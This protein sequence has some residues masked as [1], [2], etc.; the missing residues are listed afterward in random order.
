MLTIEKI[1]TNNK[2]HV[3]RFT[4]LPFRLY[5]GHPQWV[6]PLIMDLETQLNRQRHPFFEHSDV[7]FFLAVAD[8]RDV[9]R[10]AAMENK[11]F[12]KYHKTKKA[13]FY[14]FDCEDDQEI[15]DKLF[16]AVFEWARARGLDNVVGPKGM[17]P[18]DGYG[19]QTEGF[20]H[21]QMMNMM[22]Y[23]YPYYNK[24]VDAAGFTREV[25]FVSCYVDTTTFQLPERVHRIA[26]RVQKRGTLRVLKMETKKDLR[27][28]ASQV[29]VAYNKAF[30]N[31]W[32]YYPLSEREVQFVVDTLMQV[33]VP[34]LAKL[35]MHEDDVV[36]FVLGFPDISAAMQR[37]K[38]KLLPFGIIDILLEMRRTRWISFNG[39]GIL[40]EFQGRGGNALL[41]SEMVKTLNDYKF[42]HAELTQVANTA[43]EMRADLKNL[44]SK[45][46][47]NHRVYSRYI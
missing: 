5:A 39:A 36:G 8:G 30:V 18:F 33:L 19:I 31:N 37:I 11:P 10:I 17:S 24:L 40:P 32:E 21:R 45:E 38:G 34:R 23:N 12:N 42:Q 13:Q 29:G 41:Y 9:G 43:V 27:K 2:E 16:E 47:K 6:P 15:A 28:I 26:E 3:R 14:F 22:N 25:D 4:R 20:E 1:D 35:I 46:Y 7:D 44:N